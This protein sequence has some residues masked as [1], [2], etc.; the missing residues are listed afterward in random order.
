MYDFDNSDANWRM[1]IKSVIFAPLDGESP[2]AGEIEVRGVAF[3]DGA[4]R[5]EAVELSLDD[6]QSWRRA[7]LKTPRSPYAWYPWTARL[8]LAKGRQRILARAVDALGRTQPLDGTID[9]N[10]AGYGWHGVHA[11]EVTAV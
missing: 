1:R 3:N 7:V 11:V 5:I 10:P 6:G 8:T 4:T 2:K 9:W